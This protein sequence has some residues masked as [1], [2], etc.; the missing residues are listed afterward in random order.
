MRCKPAGEYHSL[1]GMSGRAR[2]ELLD[3]EIFRQADT[4]VVIWWWTA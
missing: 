4:G 2:A 3:R 1:A